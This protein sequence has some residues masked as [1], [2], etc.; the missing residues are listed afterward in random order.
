MPANTVK[1]LFAENHSVF[2][3]T[4]VS[5]FLSGYEIVIVPSIKQAQARMSQDSFNLI[6]VDYD[7]DDGKGDQL[8]REARAKY[9][10]LRIIGVSAHAPGNEALLDAGA[11]AICS[12]MNFDTIQEVIESLGPPED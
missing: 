9:P 2:A 5:Q 7:L 10:E 1:I 6:L 8:V 11:S 3:K 12:K 4:V